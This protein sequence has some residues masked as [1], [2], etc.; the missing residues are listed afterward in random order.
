MLDTLPNRLASAQTRAARRILTPTSTQAS[1]V[2][3][4][5]ITVAAG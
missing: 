3:L 4:D 5:Y 2:K 1:D